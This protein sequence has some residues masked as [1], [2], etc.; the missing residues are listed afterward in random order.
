MGPEIVEC[1]SSENT[2]SIVVHTHINK[3]PE[4][5]KKFKILW[6]V[7]IELRGQGSLECKTKNEDFKQRITKKKTFEKRIYSRA[8]KG[9]T[10]QSKVL[11]CSGRAIA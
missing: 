4:F 8:S 9:M 2:L 7:N 11:A 1:R 10:C 5:Q 6:Y 3:G